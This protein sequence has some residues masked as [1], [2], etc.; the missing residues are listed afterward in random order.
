MNPF[1]A[2]LGAFN[3]ILYAGVYTA[4]KR[5]SVVNT[6]VGAVVGAIPPMMGWT[7]C[8]GSLLP[9]VTSPIILF[10]PDLDPSAILPGAIDNPLA[11]WTL[12]A[13]LFSWQFPHFNSFSL[14]TA[15]SYAQAGFRMLSVLDPRKNAVV[16]LRHAALLIAI[17]SVLTPLSGL[18]TWWFALS[19]LPP[20]A[21]LLRAAWQFWRTNGGL[22]EA[23][24]RIVWRISLWW[25]PLILG[26]MMIHKKDA[27]WGPVRWNEEVEVTDEAAQGTNK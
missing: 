15:S 3:I 6:W 21:I 2:A 7:A 8:G 14:M 9:S 23:K 1:T 13:L 11:V 20:N 18:T 22:S 12:A 26:L 10:L 5:T 17:C 24:A 27:Q 16:S 25:L 19:S 4:L